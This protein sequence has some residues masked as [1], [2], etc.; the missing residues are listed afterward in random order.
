MQSGSGSPLDIAAGFTA[1]AELEPVNTIRQGLI[2]FQDLRFGA[3]R[4]KSA[5]RAELVSGLLDIGAKSTSQ[6]SFF[7]S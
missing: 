1:E 5:A 6:M 4:T 3:K 7:Q 2:Q